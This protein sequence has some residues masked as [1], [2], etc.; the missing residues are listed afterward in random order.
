MF[1][2]VWTPGVLNGLALAERVRAKFPMIPVII[3]SSKTNVEDAASR[4]GGF[5][6]KQ[7]E[8]AGVA[9]MIAQIV[10]PSCKGR[11]Q[12]FCS[13]EGHFRASALR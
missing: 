10:V 13:G 4:L 9:N 3:T 12:L 7:F 11:M 2:D 6:P 8:P 5:V 1:T